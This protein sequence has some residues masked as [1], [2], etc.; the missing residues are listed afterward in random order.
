M[1]CG[2]GGGAGSIGRKLGSVMTAKYVAA[3]AKRTLAGNV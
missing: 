1:G 3:F 2:G